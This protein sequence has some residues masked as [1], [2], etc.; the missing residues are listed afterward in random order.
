[1]RNAS[2]LHADVT[3]LQGDFLQP[4]VDRNIQ[5][6]IIVSN[7]PYID[8]AD[9][10]LLTDTV[11]KFDPHLA[12]FAENHG[13]AAYETIMKQSLNISTCTQIYFENGYDQAISVSK[14][15]HQ[16]YPHSHIEKVVDI[17]GND[18]I[19]SISL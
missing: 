7:P 2:N 17:N 3:F 14:I 12:L 6:E 10:Y 4:V 16:R 9:D 8:E 1:E 15:V 13:L 11:K 18:R 5:P 19:I